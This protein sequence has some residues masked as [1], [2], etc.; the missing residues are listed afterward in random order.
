LPSAVENHQTTC[1]F[2][3][4]LANISS[5]SS[6]IMISHSRELFREVA[7]WLKPMML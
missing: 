6:I 3:E 5:T 7:C 4:L 2:S 1:A